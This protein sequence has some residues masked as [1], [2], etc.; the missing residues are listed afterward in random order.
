MNK[1]RLGALNV[2][3]D[4]LVSSKFKKGSCSVI[5]DT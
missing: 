1:L 3:K 5:P 4:L 2:G